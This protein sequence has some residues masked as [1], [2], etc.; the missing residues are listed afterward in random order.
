VW[1]SVNAAELPEE[2]LD[3]VQAVPG[4]KGRSMGWTSGRLPPTP[5]TGQTPV[6]RR[7]GQWRELSPAIGLTL[8]GKSPQ[9]SI[10]RTTGREATVTA[11]PYHQW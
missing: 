1:G 3:L 9:Q 8:L 11:L 6:P 4:A 10:A 2:I 7:T 5:L